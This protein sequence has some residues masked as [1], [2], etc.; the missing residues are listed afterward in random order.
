[1]VP[2]Q[3]EL[4]GEK[5]ASIDIGIRGLIYAPDF[6]PPQEEV[7][8]IQIIDAQTWLADLKRRVQRYGK[9]LR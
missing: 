4:F 7:D 3:R 1:M 2:K 9:C 6:I 5:N 8:L